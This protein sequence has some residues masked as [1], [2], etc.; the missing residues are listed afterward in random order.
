MSGL[1]IHMFPCLKDN[2]GFLLHDANAGVTACV[3][4]PDAAAILAA[5]G[6]QGWALTHILN[7]HH[8][9]DHAG[10]N[11]ELKAVTGCRIIGPRSDPERIPG[12]D[13]GVGE[14]DEFQLGSHGVRV[15]ETPGH[16]RSH[17]VYWLP[18]SNA[19]FV[20]DTLFA[21]GC[22]R[23]FEGTPAQMWKSL[24]KIAALPEGTRLYCAHEY[25]QANARFALTVE[26][27][28]ADLIARSQQVDRMRARGEPTVPTTVAEERA[29]N[30]FL[31]PASAGLQAAVGLPGAD[32]VSVFA[33][34]RALKDEM[35]IRA[36]AAAAAAR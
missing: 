17:V 29:T 4:T 27:D 8:H 32:E 15:L 14:G 25:T 2:Y 34:T 23:I 28:N 5:L 13:Q 11:L 26:P 16:T 6:G 20:G 9:A 7:T 22:G 30:P 21:M 19:A 12:M 35:R 31:R 24:Q 3:D 33:K 1:Q 36:Q 18:G 10:G